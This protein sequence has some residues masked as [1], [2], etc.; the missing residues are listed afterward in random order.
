L[1]LWNGRNGI[2]I[3]QFHARKTLM[4]FRAAIDLFGN[5][6]RNIDLIWILGPEKLKDD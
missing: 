5:E 2:R 6:G 3:T 1:Q 4:A